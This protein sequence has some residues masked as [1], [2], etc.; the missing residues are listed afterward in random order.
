MA[1]DINETLAQYDQF[2]RKEAEFPGFSLEKSPRIVRQLSLSGHG[3]MVL[4]SGL[5]ELTADAAIDGE[6]RFFRARG[7]DFEWKLYS[8]D[9]PIDLKERLAARGLE[10]GEDEALMA[11]DLQDWKDGPESAPGVEI[12]RITDP[13]DL[14][15]MGPVVRGVW[16]DDPEDS[17][18]EFREVLATAPECMSFYIA[19][20]DGQPVSFCRISFPPKSPFASLWGGSTLEAFRGRGI[21]TAFLQLRVK[22]ARSR[23]Y[24]YLTIDASP[25]SRPIVARRGFQLLAITNPCTLEGSPT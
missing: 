24:R 21:Y 20:V 14:D 19:Y 16:G 2:E 5:D 11:L 22:E 10:I 15:D 18:P 8:H 7:Q 23:G 25:M 12:R 17:L 6:L 3:N 4:W 1:M 13:A 9:R